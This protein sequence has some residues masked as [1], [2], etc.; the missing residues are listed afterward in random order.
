MR[1]IRRLI[2]FFIPKSIKQRI[3]NHGYGFRPSRV[4]IPYRIETGADGLTAVFASGS[5][6]RVTETEPEHLYAIVSNG[7]AVEEFAAFD[8]AGGK[9]FFD[10]GAH[11]GAFSL[12][13]CAKAEENIAVA[14]EP[15]P[16]LTTIARDL[17]RLNGV[18]NRLTLIE[19]A[20]GMKVGEQM[21]NI[22]P[23]GFV[24]LGER[25][26]HSE[27]VP[28]PVVT[29]DSECRRLGFF[30]DLVKID[31]EG[32]EYEVLSGAQELLRVAR[33]TLFLE[34]HLDMLQQRGI[35]IHQVVSLVTDH[36]YV[37]TDL[38]GRRMSAR[39][40]P[41]S[42]KGIIRLIAVPTKR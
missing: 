17:I 20:V 22:G 12:L 31:V 21:G 3:A 26:N 36:Q 29:L 37:F 14:Y 30:P 7:E 8:S 28:I 4:P 9:I 1:K 38:I 39:S 5:R 25:I 27:E 18:A 33:P 40:V 32:Y 11:T 23:T 13:F 19:S 2:G 24:H 35:S 16:P 41:R 15:S 10:V 6:I 34:L 42:I